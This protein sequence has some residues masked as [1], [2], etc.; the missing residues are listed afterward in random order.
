M[1]IP[2]FFVTI[3]RLLRHGGASI[4]TRPP[5]LPPGL[6][7]YNSANMTQAPKDIRSPADK[8]RNTAGIVGSI[9]HEDYVLHPEKGGRAS[10]RHVG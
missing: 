5:P 1:S 9:E 6:W 3:F 7:V 4:E 2:Q 10:T 8:A